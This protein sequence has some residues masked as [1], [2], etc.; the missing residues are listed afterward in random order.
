[1]A[2]TNV[3]FG[4][5]PRAIDA[6]RGAVARGP[7]PPPVPRP[8]PEVAP[9]SDN[10]WP[11][12]TRQGGVEPTGPAHGSAWTKT[13]LLQPPTPLLVPLLLLLPPKKDED[14]D[15]EDDALDCPAAAV[16]L[17]LEPA[18][19]DKDAG[20]AG[21]TASKRALCA[22]RTCTSPQA[23]PTRRVEGSIRRSKA[24]HTTR[25]S[26]TPGCSHSKKPGPK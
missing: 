2:A 12:A 5:L 16:L 22:H 17:L 19:T 7:A 18:A 20:V 11:A 15:D 21:K 4:E 26:R 6:S 3:V 24:T 23:R 13:Q 8:P 9:N 10:D 14:D 25:W 1:V